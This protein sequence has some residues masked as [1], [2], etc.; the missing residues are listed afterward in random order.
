MIKDKDVYEKQDY[1]AHK[2]LGWFKTQD[3]PEGLGFKLTLKGS[4]LKKTNFDK[5]MQLFKNEWLI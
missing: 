2:V 1:K 4:S 3:I 5:A